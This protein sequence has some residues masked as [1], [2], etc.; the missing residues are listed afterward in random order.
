M[1]LKRRA[2]VTLD[3][4][5][6]LGAKP[7]LDQLWRTGQQWMAKQRFARE[8]KRMKITQPQQCDI[9]GSQMVLD[10]AKEGIDRDLLL[11][12][13]REPVATGHLMRIL[14]AD[15][16]LLEAGANIG[17]YTLL[18]ARI[19]RKVYSVEPHPENFER[20][21]SHVTLNKINNVEL[22]NLAFGPDNND[23][24]LSCSILSNWHSCLPDDIQAG[25]TI[26][27][28]GTTIDTFV[29]AHEQ[30]TYLRMDIEGFEVEVLKGAMST[31]PKLRGLFVELHG[32]KLPTAHI[33]SMLD[34]IAQAG[35]S[36]SMIIQYDW[37][38]TSLIH[39]LERFNCI[40]QGDRC[41]YELFFEK[42]EFRNLETDTTPYSQ[43]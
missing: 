33:R 28:E 27:V 19:C 18:C 1:G 5:R 37:P 42:K 20:L 2:Q 41:T 11:H 16:V 25:E 12:R 14:R 29:R 8:F 31:L 40:Y 32:P 23:L 34:Q 6:S 24:T 38:G 4:W 13:I 22:K 43:P 26:T 36:P 30:P 7:A 9:L 17:Y 39:P 35:L 3:M 21:K 15:D 10:P